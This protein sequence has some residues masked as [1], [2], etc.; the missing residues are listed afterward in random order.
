MAATGVH[1]NIEVL[2]YGADSV[3]AKIQILRS[4][5]DPGAKSI[6]EQ[7][8]LELIGV[9]P[10]HYEYPKQNRLSSLA[11]STL[12]APLVPVTGVAIPIPSVLAAL[13]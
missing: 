5:Q 7:E 12:S 3:Y 9:L 11:N 13:S 8:L 10:N 4:S 1:Q 2:L 6:A